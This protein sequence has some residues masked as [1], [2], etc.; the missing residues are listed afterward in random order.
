MS[1]NPH[2]CNATR[3]LQDALNAPTRIPNDDT[4]EIFGTMSFSSSDNDAWRARQAAILDEAL[5]VLDMD[6]TT[7]LEEELQRRRNG[8]PQ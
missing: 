7:L 1:T 3:A 6:D 4:I 5:R 8:P 2:A